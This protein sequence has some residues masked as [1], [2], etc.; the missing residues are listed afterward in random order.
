MPQPNFQ[1]ALTHK[2]EKKE[3]WTYGIF[4]LDTGIQLFTY[5]Y[6]YYTIMD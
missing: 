4:I 1:H 3:K 5:Y 2:K 6:Y